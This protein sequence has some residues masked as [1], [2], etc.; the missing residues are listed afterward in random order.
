MLNFFKSR[1]KKNLVHY[2]SNCN[3]LYTVGIG[4]YI[5]CEVFWWLS[6]FCFS[7][8]IQDKFLYLNYSKF[9]TAINSS[10]EEIKNAIKRFPNLKF[11][12]TIYFPSKEHKLLYVYKNGIMDSSLND[13]LHTEKEFTIT[14]LFAG[15]VSYPI[16]VGL[17]PRTIGLDLD[18]YDP[19]EFG[20]DIIYD[21]LVEN[22][23]ENADSN[24]IS[25]N[26][27]RLD[28]LERSPIYP[29]SYIH[30][31]YDD[32]LII[33]NTK[34]I[35]RYLQEILTVA[36]D[37]L[38]NAFDPYKCVANREPFYVLYQ[39]YNEHYVFHC[40]LYNNV[41]ELVKEIKIFLFGFDDHSSFINAIDA[42]RKDMGLMGL[43]DI[44][45]DRIN[46]CIATSVTN[47]ILS[48]VDSLIEE[49]NYITIKNIL[50]KLIIKKTPFWFDY[51]KIQNILLENGY[52]QEY[53]LL[54]NDQY[55]KT[56]GIKNTLIFCKHKNS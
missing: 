50:T 26:I 55:F 7:T 45:L 46:K 9:S 34:R 47:T 17:V 18:D 21:D 24:E 13:T 33:Y 10:S 37:I 3:D 40:K 15:N 25:I 2:G 44:D 41:N 14:E 30:H 27:M 23:S 38:E 12:R 32:D 16:Q 51:K 29:M 28:Y 39:N 42:E 8:E 35:N 43:N 1:L 36:N 56:Q 6:S 20:D 22:F 19:L 11:I 49:N 53:I 5:K 48:V 52:K 31:E 54:E 4:P